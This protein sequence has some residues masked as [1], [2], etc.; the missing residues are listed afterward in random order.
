MYKT[1]ARCI[2]IEE[3][4]RKENSSI[5]ILHHTKMYLRLLLLLLAT[6][7]I[8]HVAWS[9][10]RL[11]GDGDGEG[12]KEALLQYYWINSICRETLKGPCTVRLHLG[13]FVFAWNFSRI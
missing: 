9:R 3:K 10:I 4:E 5:W 8:T 11:E 12:R 6:D 7:C 2:A 1:R 13:G